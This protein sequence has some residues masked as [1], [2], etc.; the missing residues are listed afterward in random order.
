MTNERRPLDEVLQGGM[1]AAP[2]FGEQVLWDHVTTGLG[3]RLRSGS[4]STWIYR[5]RVEGKLI[6]QTLARAEA[7]NL[8]QARTAAETVAVAL[9]PGLTKVSLRQF[10]E[11]FMRDCAGRWKVATIEGHRHSLNKLILPVLGKLAVDEISYADVTAWLDGLDVAGRSKDRATSVLS[12]LI[13]HAE[14]LG[15]RP[16]GSN[17]CAGRRRHR[18]DFEARYLTARDYR[19]LALALDQAAKAD[20]VEVACIRF[21]MLTGAR[22]GEA[23]S[24]EW[25]M[26][27]RD[28]ATLPDSKTGPKCLWFSTP[29][30]QIL[31]G[32]DR[33]KGSPN[34]F[35][36]PCGR[37]IDSSLDRVWC[38][39][40]RQ[41]GL[42]GLRLHDLRHSYAS[43]AVG[44]GEE[45]RTVAV[46][47][48]HSQ[49]VT[50][51]GYAHLVE[52]PVMA[53]AQRIDDHL[54]E[55]LTPSEP[56]KPIQPESW[57]PK[58]PSRR[59]SKKSSP[60][61]LEEQ[62]RMA[63][64]YARTEPPF[65]VKSTGR[66]KP[67]PRKRRKVSE[68]DRRWAPYIRAWRKTRLKL[69]AFCEREGLDQ[70]A[71]RKAIARHVQH[72]KEKLRE[73]RP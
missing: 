62:A 19:R 7:M 39:V 8:E 3:L 28:R 44:N 64:F 50:T 12:S 59:S 33:V 31:A 37:G 63:A 4:P 11:T 57:M 23:L 65:D 58:P 67:A 43:V 5:R 2:T 21:L 51:M 29:V 41:A 24:L 71:M 47:L 25:S 73:D 30:R 1:P 22:R 17:P 72:V 9:S 66:A 26:V 69:S 27:Q 54:S 68:E 6:K 36:C 61:L 38:A 14:T 18:S 56:I 53:A 10:A 70:E 13:R 48:G 45:L 40:R 46:L 16:A 42:D 34:V 20:P 60:A 15:L 52:Q 35:V 55:A 32:L 49:M